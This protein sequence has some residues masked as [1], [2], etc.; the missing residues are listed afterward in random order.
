MVVGGR[1]PNQDENESL[2]PEPGRLRK[3]RLFLRRRFPAEN[4]IARRKTAERGSVPKQ[5]DQNNDEQHHRADGQQRPLPVR[6]LG[7]A[8]LFHGRPD[9][10]PEQKKYDDGAN[11]DQY[12]FPHCSIT[13]VVDGGPYHNK[14][15]RAGRGFKW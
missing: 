4:G 15:P 5:H 3:K 7:L 14:K 8:A 9:A 13:P 10:R 11:A 2:N 12:L 1:G 6:I